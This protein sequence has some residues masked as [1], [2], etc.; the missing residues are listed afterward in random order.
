MNYFKLRQFISFWHKE[1]WMSS[2]CPLLNL[3]EHFSG[4]ISFIDSPD[5]QSAAA[6]LYKPKCSLK[7][8]SPLLI[9]ALALTSCAFLGNARNFATLYNNVMSWDSS[10]SIVGVVVATDFS[11]SLFSILL[12][13]FAHQISPLFAW[14]LQ[15]SQ[16]NFSCAKGPVIY[17]YIQLLHFLGGG[18]CSSESLGNRCIRF[19]ENFFPISFELCSP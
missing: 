11:A 10:F 18:A 2:S 13:V 12:F 3:N 8:S 4:M 1:S 16:Q 19:Y 6:T 14:H 9:I 17:G 5:S 7:N 15:I